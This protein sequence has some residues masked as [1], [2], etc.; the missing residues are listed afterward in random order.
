MAF[1]VRPTRADKK[2]ARLISR[3]TTRRTEEA[4]EILTLG[5]DGRILRAAAAA[6]WLYCRGK[7]APQRRAADHILVT[8]IAARVLAHLLRHVFT[9]ARP[10]RVSV[11]AHLRGAPFSGRPL[12][13]FPLGHAIHV[14]AL[15]SAASGMPALQRNLVWT[16]SA[17]VVLTRVV[18]LAHCASDVAAGLFVGD[19]LERVIR[20]FT[21][22]RGSDGS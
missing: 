7:P 2:V 21:G 12:Q 8:P 10:N 4:A 11:E 22:Y 3:I 20:L 16:A 13:S 6:W 19:V 14:G 15:G 18:L 5:A 17:G 9:Q 1:T